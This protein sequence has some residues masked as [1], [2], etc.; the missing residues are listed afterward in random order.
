MSEL[1]KDSV[2]VLNF[3]VVMNM[4]EISQSYFLTFLMLALNSKNITLSENITSQHYFIFHKDCASA[5]NSF[6][7]LSCVM[8]RN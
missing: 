4:H 1:G 8:F 3:C 5:F 6:C 2:L 7:T